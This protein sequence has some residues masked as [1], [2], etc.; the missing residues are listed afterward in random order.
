M[1]SSGFRSASG[2]LSL[3]P[4]PALPGDLDLRA[5][6]FVNEEA[7]QLKTTNQSNLGIE[8]ILALACQRLAVAPEQVTFWAS[9]SWLNTGVIRSVTAK[10]GFNLEIIST[11]QMF[12]WCVLGHCVVILPILTTR[13]SFSNYLVT[14]Y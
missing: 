8:N 7:P 1:G 2:G 13:L 3:Q 11:H 5:L 12:K 10:S 6:Y 4:S 14:L 9:V